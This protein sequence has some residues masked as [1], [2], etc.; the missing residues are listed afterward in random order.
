MEGK[1]RGKQGK[2]GGKARKKSWTERTVW[3][4]F[5]KIN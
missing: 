2:E 5:Y 1:K 4:L 3:V